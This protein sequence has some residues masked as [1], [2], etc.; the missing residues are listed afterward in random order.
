MVLLLGAV[1]QKTFAQCTAINFNVS[2]SNLCINQVVKFTATNAP[3]NTT[4]SWIID[5]KTYSGKSLDT[6]SLGF[7][8]LGSYDVT[9]I[10][11]FTTAKCTLKKSGFINVFNPPSKPT[12]NISSNRLCDVNQQVELYSQLPNIAIWNWTV[13]QALYRNNDDSVKH[14]FISSGFFNVSLQVIDSNGC[15]ATAR[16]DSAILVEKKPA[17]TLGFKD[18]GVCDTF[19]LYPAA[20]FNLFGQKNFKYEWNFGKG[21]PSNSNKK[22]PGKS[23]FDDVGNH[24]IKLKI[25]SSAGCEHNYAFKDSIH[26]GAKKTFNVYKNAS[27]PCNSHKIDLTITNSNIFPN[28][29][30]WSFTGDSLKASYAGPKAQIEYLKSGTFNYQ[31]SHYE[32]GCTSAYL[33]SNVVKINKLKADFEL[34][35]NCNCLAPDTFKVTNKSILS[36]VANPDYSWHIISANNQIAHSA[37]GANPKLILNN[38]GE[39]DV[40]LILSDGISCSDTLKMRK[41]IKI[42]NLELG[43][44]A[45]PSVAC[46][47]QNVEFTLDSGCTHNLTNASWRFY[48]SAGIELASAIGQT[49]TQKFAS[50]GFYSASVAAITSNGCYD[51]IFRKNILEV[52]SIKKTSFSLSDTT[53]CED[54]IINGKV[55]LDPAD[56][57]ANINWQLVRVANGKILQAKPVVGRKNEFL[58]RPENA[59]NYDMRLVVNGGDGCKDS[60][61]LKNFVK[62]AGIEGSIK[63]DNTTGCLPFTTK[64]RAQ[65]T[66]N[67]HPDFPNDNT[68]LYNWNVLPKQNVSLN[69][70]TRSSSDIIINQ[71]GEYNVFLTVTN[72]SG[73]SETILAEDLFEF[74]FEAGFQVDTHTCQN[75]VLHPINTTNGNNL[76]HK[77]FSNTS[78]VVFHSTNTRENPYLSFTQPGTYK[79]FLVSELPS[80]CKDTAVKTIVVEPFGIDFKLLNPSPKCTP[81]Q[82]NFATSSNNIDTFNWF[83]GDGNSILTDQKDIGHV[84]D[85]STVK[86]F[87]NFFSPKLIAKNTMGCADTI[88]KTNLVEVLGPNP[89]FSI[90]NPKGCDPHIVRFTDS[91]QQVERFYFHYDDG[92]SAD[93]VSFAK[94]TYTINNAKA[95]QVFKP[96][97]IASDKY[98][99]FVT[100]QPTD[101]ILVYAQPVADFE[102]ETAHGCAPFT[103]TLKN[104]SM[105]GHKHY[106]DFNNDGKVDDSTLNPTH[107]FK[108]GYHTIKLVV[109]NEI[110]CSTEVVKTNVLHVTQPPR[111]NFSVSDTLICPSI[112]MNLIDRT[113]WA[114]EL[115]EWKWYIKTDT[116]TVDSILGQDVTYQFKEPG[117]YNIAIAAV[118]KMGCT[119]TLEKSKLIEVKDRLNLI[120]PAIDYITILNEETIEISWNKLLLKGFHKTHLLKNNNTAT[121]YKVFTDPFNDEFHDIDPS[122]NTQPINYQIQLIDRCSDPNRLSSI[123]QTIF[124]TATR[125]DRPFARLS[126]TKYMGWDSVLFYRLFKREVGG[127]FSEVGRF[128]N[129]DTFYI[130]ETVCNIEYEYLV[131]AIDPSGRFFSNSNTVQFSPLFENANSP[132]NFELATVENNQIK[133]RWET[134][135]AFNVDFYYIDKY[136]PIDGWREKWRRVADTTIIDKEAEPDKYPYKYRVWFKDFCGI[137]NKRSNTGSN[138]L[139]QYSIENDENFLYFWNQYDSWQEGV[140]TYVLQQSAKPKGVFQDFYSLGANDTFL[141]EKLRAIRADSIFFARVIA[142]SNNR[143]DTSI[144][145]VIKVEPLATMYIPNAFSPDNDGINEEFVYKGLAFNGTDSLFNIVIFNRWGT[146]VFES[147]TYNNF[148]DGR[149]NG[150]NCPAGNYLYIMQFTGVD[151]QTV[152][153]KGKVSL[154]R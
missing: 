79:L 18:T 24:V 60:L 120:D 106:W 64:L 29:F 32:N 119:D 123:H 100:Y 129:K 107:T 35:H 88:Y 144:S 125:N 118:D 126:W 85:L 71:V 102:L 145:N 147:N 65:I 96:Y 121:P 74:N 28:S 127:E 82:Y 3:A 101:S 11:D 9:L 25:I 124:L 33:D 53:V 143:K 141:V 110:G 92:T 30:T 55:E 139:L 67:V 36:G 66:R 151:N 105:F 68:I 48:N 38:A 131:T 81:A 116:L 135:N 14:T 130:D 10:T 103:T 111:A 154:L 136:H 91:T 15:Q 44:K 73:C 49:V 51:S 62:V 8:K 137:E 21:F 31:I 140:S 128:S 12:I 6:L 132:I 97:I 13:G 5:G 22:F 76:K 90:N 63:A 16:Y 109:V 47:A 69:N 75:M 138:I 70:P 148:W 104:M 50:S 114:F 45:S 83:F 115:V 43:I 2:D 78:N 19:T 134:S 26:I 89:T 150:E 112:K 40:R 133:L 42:S 84:Y 52:T 86:P 20:K 23:F 58:L 56:I 72:S 37:S 99:C 57:T 113:N 46:G 117:K 80:G 87:R 77:W 27:P 108:A 41:A 7:T 152:I 1:C 149:F 54:N 39:F 98:K 142:L 153:K 59:G 95:Y 17:V 93:S 4:Y 34:D 146:K 94:H 61:Y 122:L